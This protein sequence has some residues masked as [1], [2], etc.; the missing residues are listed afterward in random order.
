[1]RLWRCERHRRPEWGWGYFLQGDDLLEFAVYGFPDDAV[2]PFA[3][4]LDYLV[5]FE[6]V[7]LD[8]FSHYSIKIIFFHNLIL[9]GIGLDFDVCLSLMAL[10]ASEEYI[11]VE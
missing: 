7:R 6:D 1:V 8:F 10:A 9:G 11:A 5:L 3:Q 4:F 2:G